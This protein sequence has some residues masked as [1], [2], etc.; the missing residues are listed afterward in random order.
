MYIIFILINTLL[1]KSFFRTLKAN[2]FAKEYEIYI[3][4]LMTSPID[5][6]NFNPAYNYY[7]YSVLTFLLKV[8]F[9]ASIN[10][11]DPPYSVYAKPVTT[12]G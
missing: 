6:V 7:Y 3:D 9:I 4:S 12:P 1:K 2:D 11:R 10:I 5:P 8:L